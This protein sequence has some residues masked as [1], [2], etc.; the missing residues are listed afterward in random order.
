MNLSFVIYVILILNSI[1]IVDCRPRLFPRCKREELSKPRGRPEKEH[2]HALYRGRSQERE[3]TAVVTDKPMA[4]PPSSLHNRSVGV[5]PASARLL[6]HPR[7][8][9]LPAAGETVPASM[10]MNRPEHQGLLK[11]SGVT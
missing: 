11:D 7:L 3:V 4:Q 1:I 9:S 10:T 6:N 2:I 8:P 5:S